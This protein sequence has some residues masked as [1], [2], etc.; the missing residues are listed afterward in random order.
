MSKKEKVNFILFCLNQISD[1][2]AIKVAYDLKTIATGL[3]FRLV[4]AKWN[5]IPIGIYSGY[6]VYQYWLAKLKKHGYLAQIEGVIKK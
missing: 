5:Q 6:T 1:K 4:G 2:Q 3:Y